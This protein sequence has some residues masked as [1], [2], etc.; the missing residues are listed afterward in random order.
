MENLSNFGNSIAEGLEILNTA[1]QLPLE[2][3]GYVPSILGAA[4]SVV[5]AVMI[6]KFILGR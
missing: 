1:I 6:V 2:I 4:I 5:V 3:I